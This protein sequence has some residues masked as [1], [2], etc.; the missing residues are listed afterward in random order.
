MAFKLR[1]ADEISVD[2]WSEQLRLPRYGTVPARSTY[3]LILT[4]LLE[5]D[6]ITLEKEFCDMLLES[7]TTDYCG[8]GTDDISE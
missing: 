8:C 3:A 5:R 6:D 4:V 1:A 7:Y 2:D